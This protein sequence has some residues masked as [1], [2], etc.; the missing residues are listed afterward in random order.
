MSTGFFRELE[1]AAR[2]RQAG[3]SKFQWDGGARMWLGSFASGAALVAFGKSALAF[4]VVA[5]GLSVMFLTWILAEIIS[6][7]FRLAL[8][9]IVLLIGFSAGAF[10]T[11][12]GLFDP[13]LKQIIQEPIS[14]TPSL[15]SY[16]ALG[17]GVS[18]IFAA[19][20]LAPYYLRFRVPLAVSVAAAFFFIGAF[21]IWFYWS[22]DTAKNWTTPTTLA[23]GLFIVALAI[24]F[25]LTDR[26]RTTRRSEVAYWLYLL[27][28]VA[29]SQAIL[30]DSDSGPATSMNLIGVAVLLLLFGAVGL[31][32]D[33]PILFGAA[34]LS[35]GITLAHSAWQNA[36]P[37]LAPPL[38]LLVTATVLFGS[39]SYSQS[40]RA[41][42]VPRLPLGRLTD[43]L[44]PIQPDT[45]R[46]Q[47]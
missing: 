26:L 37:G 27:A 34:A 12:G 7:A 23:F 33:R 21:S 4:G 44:P 28:G 10:F 43:R 9:S 8:P 6:R 16:Q 17:T 42:L 15:N 30:G 14:L 25:D 22:V 36:E 41:A 1:K 35:S 18:L 11:S 3:D 47:P 31:V 5:G 2:E 32:M 29:G 24:R 38:W 13:L 45:T 20:L 46:A 40:L 39:V 19:F